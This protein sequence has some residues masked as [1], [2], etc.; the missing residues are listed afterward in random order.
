MVEIG[1]SELNL[2]ANI[3]PVCLLYF[4][5]G[6]AFLFLGVSIAVKD[7]R[8][9]EL[10]LANS[11]YLLAGFGFTHGAHE[12]L[13]LYLL[14]QG[15]HIPAEQVF[16]VKSLTVFVVILSFF[17]LLMF[18]L[19]LIRSLDEKHIQWIRLI[20][21]VLF[22][23]WI[24]YLWNYELKMDMRFLQ[25][26]DIL[27]RNTFG[28]L[29]SLTTAYGLVSYSK[30]VKKLSPVVSRNLYYA[31]IAFIFYAFS[32]GLISSHT[33]MPIIGVPVEVIRGISAVFIA[34]MVIK[35]LNIFD[36]E[37]RKKL[38]N[39]LK[40]LAQSEK[41]ASIGQLAAGIAHEI[42]NPLTNASLN[43]QTLKGRLERNSEDK[44][45]IQKLDAVERNV[46]RA[47]IIAKELLQFSRERETELIPVN[48]NKIISGALTLLS[49]KLK[50]ISVHHHLQE[51][52]E[53][54]GNPGKLEQ[55]FINIMDNA[56]EAM[57][58]EGRISIST[59]HSSS[60]ITVEI[61]DTGHG[62][63]EKASSKVF[64]PFFTTKEVGAG[65]GLGLS[66]CY[67]II[68]QHNGSIEITSTPQKGTTVTIKLPV[69]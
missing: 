32:A 65:T 12:W 68:N 61:T 22:L 60:H 26:A 15:Q 33:V 20:P 24:V 63:P 41:L 23:F 17:L 25:K 43:I 39:H 38:E 18:G 42:N 53:I 4:F 55:V 66:I 3:P 69:K 2:F 14:L 54:M 7:M 1:I 9:S 30:E 19:A 50:N 57:R 51:A 13:E 62:I 58:G 29:G 47:S 46:D 64:D 44:D 59:A 34:C 56:V 8:G 5:Y 31:G 48:I 67:G 11:L 16:L 6:L 40:L 21:T 35:A 37:T 45:V 36:I 52:P 27:S 49:H 10:K 28:F